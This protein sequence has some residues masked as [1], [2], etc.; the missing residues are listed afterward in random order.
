MWNRVCSTPV[1]PLASM[2]APT[3]AGVASA[4]GTP[5][6]ISTAATAAPRVRMLSVAR[7]A[8]PKMRKVR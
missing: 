3:A 4:G 5:A 8:K 2:P 6:A 1:T 7:S